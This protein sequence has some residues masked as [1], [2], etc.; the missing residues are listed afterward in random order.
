MTQTFSEELR[1]FLYRWV[2]FS[3]ERGSW[4]LRAYGKLEIWNPE[5]ENGNGNGTGTGTGTGI[6]ERETEDFFDGVAND[7]WFHKTF[8]L[9]LLYFIVAF[10]S[11]SVSTL[12]YTSEL[13]LC[14]TICVHSAT[15]HN[16]YMCL[17][18]SSLRFTILIVHNFLCP[19]SE[20][21]R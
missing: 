12:I 14:S 10:S 5:S 18:F 7:N 4:F 19:T 9:C 1:Q 16:I 17:T 20:L 13:I 21:S 11:F 8:Y 3:C 6:R 15:R 2:C